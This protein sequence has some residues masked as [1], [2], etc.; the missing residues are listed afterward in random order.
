MN[1]G[2]GDIVKI[3]S[4]SNA[5]NLGNTNLIRGLTV[6]NTTGIGISGSNFGT[7][8][9]LDTSITDTG[10]RTGQALGLGTPGTLAATFDNLVSSSAVNGVSLTGIG[11]NLTINA[12]ALSVL[13][14]SDFLVSGGSATI[15][16]AGTITNLALRAAPWTCKGIRVAR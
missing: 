13:T 6:G 11:G 14:G 12:G 1:S 9:V 16:Y 10:T 2:N 15:S 8:T 3:T 4:A 7:L 5:I